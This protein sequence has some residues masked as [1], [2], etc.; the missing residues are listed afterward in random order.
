M[1]E[2]MPD[3]KRQFWDTF[4]RAMETE[5]RDV[6]HVRG[7]SGFVHPILAAGVDESRKRTLIVSGDPDA[8]TAALA[9]AD[10]QAIAPSTKIIL[11][12]PIAINLQS[13]A[14]SVIGQLG[15]ARLPFSQLTPANPEDTNE[16]MRVQELFQ[17]LLG[18]TIE[19]VSRPFKYVELN[20]I[21]FV[22]E[23]VQQLSLV[24][25][26]GLNS[27]E[28]PGV[29]D[30]K[31]TPML[32]LEQLVSFDPVAVDRS[33]GVCAIPLYQLED[34]D[35][36]TFSR[37]D[38]DSA[39]ACLMKH[40]VFQYFFPPAD[41]IALAASDRGVVSTPESLYKYVTTAPEIGHPLAPNEL[42][43]PH[44]RITELVDALQDRGLLVEGSGAIE[45]SPTGQEVR[46]ELKFR[47]R[48]GLMEKLSRVL[49]VKVDINLKDIFK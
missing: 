30:F 7:A 34:D 11:A 17:S 22:K 37:G 29:P 28:R 9:Q 41:Q 13:F 39:R 44:A 40:H 5:P 27:A 12:R 1:V 16:K 23:L 14:L 21:S 38:E 18:G 45:I 43:D 24:Q 2:S 32:I 33:G 15:A 42:V 3:P 25:L 47:P 48:E 20:T 4:L 26:D 31:Q 10:I 49:S 6:R 36:D 8:R 46:A 35:F 19:S